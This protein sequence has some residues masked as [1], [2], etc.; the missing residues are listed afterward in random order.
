MDERRCSACGLVKPLSD[1]RQRTGARAGKPR[2]YCRPCDQR[3]T[4]AWKQRNAAK[5]KAARFSWEMRSLYGITPERY[6]ELVA[7]Q[8][9]ACAICGGPPRG[10]GDRLHV[11]HDHETGVVRGLC[12][13]PCNVGIGQLGHDVGRLRAAIKYL[14]G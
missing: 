4:R 11:D 13:S 12:C 14:G 10:K 5:V 9:G 7:A 2:S 1:F 6:A 3:A 8:N